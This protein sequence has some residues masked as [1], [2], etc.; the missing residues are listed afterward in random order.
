MARQT[1]RLLR[2][3]IVG[4]PRPGLALV[5]AA[6][7][8]CAAFYAAITSAILT[9]WPMRLLTTRGQPSCPNDAWEDGEWVK[10]DSPEPVLS[11]YEDI[12]AVSGFSGCNGTSELWEHLANRDATHWD[13]RARIGTYEWRP[14]STGSSCQMAQFDRREFILKLLRRGGWVM[15]GDST[16]ETQ[17]FSL[18]CMLH[19][20]VRVTP[21]RWEGWVWDASWPHY[22]Y[23]NTDDPWVQ[24]LLESHVTPG[25]SS[26][27]TP[28]VSFHRS[29]VLLGAHELADI[30]A[31]MS[32]LRQ[33]INYTDF[34]AEQYGFVMSRSSEKWISEFELK[35]PAGRYDTM[36]LSTGAYWVPGVFA[37]LK[38]DLPEILRLWRVSMTLLT[39]RLVKVLEVIV[40]R[41]ATPGHKGCLDD[42]SVR[43][44]SPLASVPQLKEEW[45]NWKSLGYMND[46]LED[47]VLQ[48]AHPR[49][50][51]LRLDRPGALRPDAHTLEDCLHFAVGAG[52]IED[53]TRY[54]DHFVTWEIDYDR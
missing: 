16:T 6:T 2:K 53:W 23:L 26:E 13:W 49:M 7:V 19:P 1:D 52:V 17:F 3:S 51:F 39:A 50:K 28:I 38:G 37:G 44:S 4:L 22:L 41:S 12:F 15:A 18:A 9:D 10:R 8:I 21:I 43:N 27:A 47:I 35:L 11:D 20:Y 36:I 33:P 29:D 48:H 25:F 24:H 34:W 46:V 31:T 42:L 45:F 5:F 54:I 40:F 30:A 14:R 32:G